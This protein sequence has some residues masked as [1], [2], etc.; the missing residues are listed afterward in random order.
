MPRFDGTRIK[1]QRRKKGGYAHA[2]IFPAEIGA[3]FAR[4]AVTGADRKREATGYLRE[5]FAINR[6]PLKDALKPSKLALYVDWCTLQGMTPFMI[7]MRV[8]IIRRF[9]R[10]ICIRNDW[11]DPL[12]AVRNVDF[13]KKGRTFYRRMLSRHEW[14]YLKRSLELPSTRKMKRIPSRIDK[15]LNDP[16]QRKLIYYTAIQTGYRMSELMALRCCDVVIQGKENC[17]IVLDGSLTKN[18]KDAK[19]YIPYDLACELTLWKA[20]KPMQ[21]KLFPEFGKDAS[22]ILR[23]DLDRARKLFEEENPQEAENTDFL[24][25]ID[26]RNRRLHFHSLRHTCGAWLALAGE[27]PQDVQAV[28]RHASLEMTFKQ[29]DHYFVGRGRAAVNRSFKGM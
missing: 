7:F 6:G 2:P 23:H 18:G 21:S 29:Y 24:R 17:Y 16:L 9:S 22:N 25:T 10:W 19:Q 8:Y 20:G 14:E 4:I 28:M 3:M 27:H 13:V 26:S 11:P 12:S 15:L 5:Y 1:G